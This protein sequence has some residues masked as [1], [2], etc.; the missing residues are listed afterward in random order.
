MKEIK[1]LL[2]KKDIPYAEVDVLLAMHFNTLGQGVAMDKLLNKFSGKGVKNKGKYLQ[3]KA[4]MGNAA[5]KS[6]IK[7]IPAPFST[8]M[9][10]LEI[11]LAKT[12]TVVALTCK[13]TK[14][15]VFWESKVAG[16]KVCKDKALPIAIIKSLFEVG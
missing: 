12:T 1:A 16:G 8:N 9:G 13:H 2:K 6:K 5:K 15:G 4:K 7:F 14:E 10:S 3:V 11:L